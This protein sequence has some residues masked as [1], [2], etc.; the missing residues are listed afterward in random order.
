M[1]STVI[2][3]S[4]IIGLS[5]AYYLSQLASE[6]AA[7]TIPAHDRAAAAAA[8]SSASAAA[9]PPSTPPEKHEIHLVELSPELFASASGKAAG[10]LARDWF[11]PAVT[12]LGEL[13]FDLHRRLAAAHGG[14][15]RW[16]WAESVSYSLDREEDEDA[17]EDDSDDEQDA[18]P[19]AAPGAASGAVSSRQARARASSDL[20]WLMSGSSRATL[21]GD[22]QTQAKTEAGAAAAHAAAV[23]ADPAAEPTPDT[24]E[25]YPR[26]I[27]AKRSSM[28]TISDT[29]TTGQVCVCLSFLFSV[30]GA[31]RCAPCCG[32]DDLRRT[33]HDTQTP[34]WHRYPA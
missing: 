33:V 12:P 29:T 16:G 14:R 21:L 34:S 27:R 15:E 20:D 11:A 2:L 6:P 13:S 31:V 7:D 5:T 26:W 19:D 24:E 23:D 30:V 4:G 1:P 8:S 18:D 32:R 28:Q 3:G 10:F 25:H 9:P 17:S 22:S